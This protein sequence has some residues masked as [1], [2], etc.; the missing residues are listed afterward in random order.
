M[1]A[2]C[3][4]RCSNLDQQILLF[5]AAVVRTIPARQLQSPE[6]V[7][8]LFL[9]LTVTQLRRHPCRWVGRYLRPRGVSR[10]RLTLL[11]FRL[12]CHI[13]TRLIRD[14]LLS[15][16]NSINTIQTSLRDWEGCLRARSLLRDPGSLLCLAAG[17]MLGLWGLHPLVPQ[18]AVARWV[19]PPI[20]IPRT[21]R[22][23]QRQAK[24]LL[25]VAP[26]TNRSVA[27]IQVPGL[28]LLPLA[29][30]SL[31]GA[32][33]SRRLRMGCRSA[34]SECRAKGRLQLS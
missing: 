33:H 26:P 32:V 11:R 19:P 34:G 14:C 12:R 24:A 17:V 7:R 18:V 28:G 20:L 10:Y 9:T 13:P 21:L 8:R 27:L 30:F 1:A 16:F 22:G 5:E 29:I 25:A 31:A 23:G 4:P 15:L 3:R 6:V 2:E